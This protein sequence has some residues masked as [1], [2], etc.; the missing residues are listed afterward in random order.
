MT[1]PNTLHQMAL[2]TPGGCFVPR[3]KAGVLTY[4]DAR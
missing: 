3:Y 2:V 4:T 1:P